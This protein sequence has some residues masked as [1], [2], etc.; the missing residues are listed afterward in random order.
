MESVVKSRFR[1]AREMPLSMTPYHSIMFYGNFAIAEVQKI[2][3]ACDNHLYRFDW[4]G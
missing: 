4:I 3:A 1:V 2:T